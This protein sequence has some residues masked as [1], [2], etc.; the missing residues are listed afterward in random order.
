M[1]TEEKTHTLVIRKIKFLVRKFH[2]SMRT[3]FSFSKKIKICNDNLLKFSSV[4]T[5]LEIKKSFSNVDNV[6]YDWTDAPSS[7]YCSWR[8]VTCDNTTFDVVA[9]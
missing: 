8:G 7:D 9:L 1:G 2:F 3:S 6:L 4:A 5:L